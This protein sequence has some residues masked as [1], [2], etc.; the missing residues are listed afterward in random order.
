METCLERELLYLHL[1][2]W[3][4]ISVNLMCVHVHI[5]IYIYVDHF[6]VPVVKILIVM[7]EPYRWATH[8]ILLICISPILM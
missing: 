6:R 3:V 1:D 5:Y 8:S 4:I 2:Y 7:I